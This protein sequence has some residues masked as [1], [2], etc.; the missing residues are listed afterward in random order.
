[1]HALLLTGF[2]PFPGVTDNPSGMLAESLAQAPPAGM[3]VAATVLPVTFAESPGAL[4]AFVAANAE[5]RPVLL[6]SMGVHPD[7]GF[8]LERTARAMPTS[9][10]PDEAGGT[11]L[12]DGLRAADRERSTDLDLEHLVGELAQL[13]APHGGVRVSNDAGGYVC[14]WTYQHLLQHGERLGVP[15]L[16]LH[17]PPIEHVAL[18]D[19]RRVVERLLALLANPG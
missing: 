16:F 6:L 10:K 12:D 3:S 15:A 14:D 13:A 7:E 8:R 9:T 11:G 18:A 17:V 1:M 19:Q 5:P 2:G 4:E